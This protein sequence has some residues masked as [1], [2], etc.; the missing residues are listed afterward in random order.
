MPKL[1]VAVSLL[2]NFSDK[3]LRNPLG[4]EVGRHGVDMDLHH[5][6]R[7]YSSTFLPEV[8]AEEGWDQR[9][10][11]LELLIKDD[12]PVEDLVDRSDFDKLIKGMKIT[13]Y[14]SIKVEMSYAEFKARQQPK[15]SRSR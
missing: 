8:A 11:L 15:R 13:T 12:F 1:H 6:G 14:E 9:T 5:N 2:V 7:Q 4:W 10:T 3:P